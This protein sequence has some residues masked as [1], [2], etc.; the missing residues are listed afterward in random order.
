[1]ERDAKRRL[2]A[3]E[4]LHH[5]WVTGETASTSVMAGSDKRLNKFRKFKVSD[6]TGLDGGS[7]LFNDVSFGAGS[8]KLSI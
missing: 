1:M 6:R 4:M 5:P 3:F 2:S 7:R 8:G